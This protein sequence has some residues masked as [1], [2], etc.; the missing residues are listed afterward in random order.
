MVFSSIPAY[1]D[2]ANWQQNQNF[3]SGNSELLQL[4]Q[5]Q[6]VQVPQPAP[7]LQPHGVGGAGSIRPGSM[8]DRARMA[9]IPMP[10]TALK[11]PRCDSTH[12]KFCYFNNYSLSQ[13]R[14]FCKACR[15]YWTRGGALRSVPVGGG[16]RRNKRS[17]KGSSSSSK[18]EP[19]ISETANSGSA[20]STLLLPSN[21]ATPSLNILGGLTSQIP[22]L[23]NF[24]PTLTH[25][26][27]GHELG[28][29]YSGISDPNVAVTSEMTN[30][31]TG[32]NLFSGS[33]DVGVS[34]L[35]SS[36]GG[37]LELWR[38]HHTPQFP[39]FLGGFDPTVSQGGV[40]YQNNYQDQAS[41]SGYVGAKLTSSSSMMSQLASIKMEASHNYI[42]TA[43]NQDREQSRQFTGSVQGNE[44]QWSSAGATAWTDLSG[45]TSSSTSNPL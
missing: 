17:S 8:A 9:N 11:C 14:H 12:T 28:L 43:N 21:T 34:S 39:N 4:Q 32:S 37:N 35:L 25:L 7:S 45:F 19:A 40:F 27:R 18:S 42:N 33:G 1:L 5:Q 38:M 30:F 3:Q 22:Q 44:H 31:Q 24:M 26:N 36:S 41:G 20:N 29:N 23:G 6:V 2:P 13:P 15:R 10:E 16:C